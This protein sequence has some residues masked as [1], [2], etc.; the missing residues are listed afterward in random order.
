MTVSSGRH[1][2]LEVPR[3]PAGGHAG[4]GPLDERDRHRAAL[5]HVPRQEALPPRPRTDPQRQVRPGRMRP[6]PRLAE[7]RGEDP[8]ARHRRRSRLPALPAAR[9]DDS[10]YR[11]RCGQLPRRRDLRQGAG[12]RARQRDGGGLVPVHQRVAPA[13]RRDDPPA[14]L[15]H[16]R[17]ELLR[18]QR[19]PPPR[20][21]AVR[22]RPS[23]AGQQRREGV[24]R[25]A[26]AG[27]RHARS[28]TPRTTRSSVREHRSGS[29]S[30]AS[31]TARR[32]R[33]TTSSRDKDDGVATAIAR[34]AVPARRRLAPPLPPRG[35]RRRCR[36]D[37]PALRGEPRGVGQR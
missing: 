18:L 22:L 20:V 17:P 36:R 10:R 7:R 12:G 5:R 33:P 2:P 28:G 16:R 31:R 23:N 8:S 13:R 27:V 35:D 21:L 15:L 6:L 34:L 24:Q 1:G 25:P 32:A 3:P 9:E 19:A 37:R 4:S 11:L 14:L 29:G 30:G 26:P